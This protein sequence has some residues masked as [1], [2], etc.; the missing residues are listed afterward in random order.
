MNYY[1]E[2]NPYAA[3]WLR[4]LVSAKL[5]PPGHVDDRSILDVRPTDLRGFI[6]CHFFAGIAGWP[7]A[8]QLAGFPHDERI[9]SASCPC[10]PFSHAGNRKGFDDERHLWPGFF[11]LVEIEC[12]PIVVG[13]QVASKDARG[14]ID[15]VFDDLETVGYA[16]GAV[17]FPI[18]SVGLPAKRD[19]LYWMACADS[20][21]RPRPL[22]PVN[23][24]DTTGGADSNEHA[25]ACSLGAPFRD[26]EFFADAGA[27]G[28][29]RAMPRNVSSVFNGF[30]R[31]MEFVRAY[32]N[33][34]NPVQATRFI[35]AAIECLP[36]G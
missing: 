23:L 34:I 15:L 19:R 29:I 4:N 11:H 16:C 22:Q 5:I 24:H 9:W 10:Q 8:L 20:A 35:E 6:Q 25:P 21:R 31:R 1:N 27:D 18:A 2:N 36:E 7:L 12:P 32:G 33:A 3:G 14:W 17:V 28:K 13:E 26:G 30:S